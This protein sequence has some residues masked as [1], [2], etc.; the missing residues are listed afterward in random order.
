MT[1]RRKG[2]NMKR[3][4]TSEKGLIELLIFPGAA[5]IL[6][7]CAWAVGTKGPWR[8]V[9]AILSFLVSVFALREELITSLRRKD[10]RSGLLLLIS[11]ISSDAWR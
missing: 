3:K 7:I 10:F 9:C 4:N 11:A 2:E 5:L 1:V 8:L 6:L